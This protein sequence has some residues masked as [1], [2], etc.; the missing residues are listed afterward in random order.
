M[1]TCLES[2][3]LILLGN[4][5]LIYCN[6]FFLRW[7]SL[8]FYWNNIKWFIPLKRVTPIS[9]RISYN[10]AKS[11]NKDF[12][13]LI[14]LWEW[15]KKRVYPCTCFILELEQGSITGKTELNKVTSMWKLM[16]RI[17]LWFI[18]VPLWVSIVWTLEFSVIGS[19]DIEYGLLFFIPWICTLE[20]KAI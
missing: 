12:L 5:L 11:A 13:W 2:R 4:C 18:K 6:I 17:V 10:K 15:K 8:N 20:N 14:L 9:C 3:A 7:T 19:S 1:T 16:W